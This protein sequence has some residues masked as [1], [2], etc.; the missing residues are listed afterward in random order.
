MAISRKEG[1]GDFEYI[2]TPT[3]LKEAQWLIAQGDFR[4][5]NDFIE[6]SRKAEIRMK[7]RA[8]AKTKSKSIKPAAKRG[9]AAA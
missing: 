9:K 5:M 2:L 6:S 1:Q 3:E 8:E 4:D 7:K